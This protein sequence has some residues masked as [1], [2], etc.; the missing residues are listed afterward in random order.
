MAKLYHTILSVGKKFGEL[1]ARPSEIVK[2][3]QHLYKGGLASVHG[4]FVGIHFNFL[5]VLY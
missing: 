5:Y 2:Y 1:L 3:C 4:S